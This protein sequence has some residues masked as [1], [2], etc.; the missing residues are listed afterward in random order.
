MSTVNILPYIIWDLMWNL[1]NYF[2]FGENGY[3][4]QKKKKKGERSKDKYFLNCSNSQM[5]AKM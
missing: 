2:I 3:W 5:E 4:L 1:I